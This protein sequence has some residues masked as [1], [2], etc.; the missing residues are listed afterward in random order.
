MKRILE[1]ARV[2]H[3]VNRAFCQAYGDTS[4]LPWEDAPEWQRESAVAGVIFHLDN[5]DADPERSHLAW[6]AAKQRADWKYGPV[7]DVEKKEHPCMV[8]FDQLPIEQKAKDYL[9]RA[10]VHSMK[11]TT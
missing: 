3:E 6:I 11:E 10:V 2:A 1:M 4:Q 5:P 8:P 7:K 9:F